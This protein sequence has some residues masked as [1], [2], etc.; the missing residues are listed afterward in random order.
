M[1]ISSA[2]IGSGLDVAGIVSGL[3]QV[4][5]QPLIAALLEDGLARA[6]QSAEVAPI[7]A[8]IRLLQ[9]I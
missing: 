3:M 2:G 9:L 1:A 7:A 5:R 4:E 6:R 8:Q